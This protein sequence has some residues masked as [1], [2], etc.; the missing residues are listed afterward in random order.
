MKPFDI[1][2]GAMVRE[3][4]K[5]Y[6]LGCFDSRITFYSQQVRALSLVHALYDQG[7]LKDAPRIAVIGAGAAG[8]T[9]AAAAAL[10]CNNARVILFEA[11]QD[12]VPLQIGTDR[13]KL[14]PYIYDWP[15]LDTVDTVANL[16][17]LEW[18]AGPAQTVRRD[19][20]LAFGDIAARVDGRLEQRTRHSVKQIRKLEATYEVIYD[21]LDNIPGAGPEQ[22]LRDRFDI[23]FLAVGFGIEPQETILGI[24]DN[25][26]WSNAGVPPPEFAARPR[27][28]FFI[29]GNGDGGLIDFVAAASSDF[30]HGAM[31]RLITGHAGIAEITRALIDIDIRARKAQVGGMPF[32]IF[33]AYEAEI[34]A[35]IE[36]IGLVAAVAERLRPGVQLT[37]QT[38]N[39]EIFTPNTSAL[40]R[41]AVF[42]TIKACETA[43]H[44]K[45]THVHCMHVKRVMDPAPAAGQ[46]T[47][48]LDCD[49]TQVEADEVII[50]RGPKRAEVRQPFLDLLADYEIT[51]GE[52]LNRHG[53]ETLVPTLSSEARLFYEERAKLAN[54]PL[55]RRNQLQAV[56]NLPVTFQLR[57]VGD[58]IKW[59][60]GL[61][62]ESIAEPWDS[63][64]PYKVILPDQPNALGP[65]TGAIL[66]M[67]C[68]VRQVTL[69]AD[70]AHWHG[71]V[72]QLS[73]DSIHAEG[74][75]TPV[76]DGTN[77]GGATQNSVEY[78]AERL[79]RQLHG[80]LD[81]WM[82]KNLHQHVDEFLRTGRD[83]GR[84]VGL[85]IAP[86]LRGMMADVWGRWLDAFED[87][88]KLLNHFLRLMVCAIDDENDSDIA[89]V[90]VGP[91]KLPAIIRGTVVSLAIASSWQT[92][93][94]KRIRPGNLHRERNGTTE[95]AGHGCA[96]DMING[97][98]MSLCSG[99]YM[100]QTN[101]VILS[102]TGALEVAERAEIPFSQVEVDQPAFTESAGCGPV[103][104]WISSAFTN[105][106]A[107]G[108]NALAA[109]LADI[110]SQHF[111]RLT[112]AILKLEE[113]A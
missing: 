63:D 50:R 76:I 2:E 99:S 7:Y 17:I 22:N 66:R 6:V 92:T 33:T 36:A 48:L 57:S 101:F 61:A 60:G 5:F 3:H 53:E 27:P 113:R 62:K 71:L 108:A 18:M 56:D 15:Q 12:L 88:L 82:L 25:S 85:T 90:L 4:P 87:D 8:V 79:A 41:L 65:V 26:Y 31:I 106:V 44:C 100:W 98:A 13:R 104:M 78:Q 29:S 91:K 46:A 40:N 72:C 95:W 49:G 20:V 30:D 10:A 19:V 93:A 80:T 97:K 34:Q 105:A 14:D 81:Q 28:R 86:D 103:V 32:D 69:Y 21:R 43:L 9:A 37:L 77:P 54:I 111:T 35:R 70:P 16:P 110:E 38:R 23:V 96:A 102:V 89:L 94:P 64:R 58:R 74:M 45:F 83:P 47:Y 55:S 39:A 75:S 52:W 51:H 109:L 1:I 24:A 112:T 67:A 59:S 73:G 107:T 42:A 84:S 11:S 68:H